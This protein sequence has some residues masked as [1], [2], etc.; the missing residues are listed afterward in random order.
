MAERDLYARAAHENTA[1]ALHERTAIG[2]ARPSPLTTAA[3]QLAA[4]CD[5][6]GEDGAVWPTVTRAATRRRSAMRTPPIASVVVIDTCRA[7]L[8]PRGQDSAR[9]AVHKTLKV[10]VCSR[11][12]VVPMTTYSCHE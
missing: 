9:R 6:A 1:L 7:A 12:G 4:A 10:T 3:E 11:C 5:V 2:W 8:R